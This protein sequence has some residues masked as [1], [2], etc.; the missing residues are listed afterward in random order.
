MPEPHLLELD[1]VPRPLDEER[2]RFL[3][4]RARG[5]G[6]SDIAA[7]LGISPWKSALEVYWEKTGEVEVP[8]KDNERMYWGTVTEDLIA[9]ECARRLEVEV[10]RVNDPICVDG[11]PWKRANID[12]RIVGTSIGPAVQPFLPDGH[13]WED[14]R[15]GR[16]RMGLECKQASGWLLDEWVNDNI[17]WNYQCQVQWCLYVTGW[18][19]WVFSG[20]F[21]GNDL[22]TWVIERDDEAIGRIVEVVERFWHDHVEKGCPPPPGP[23]EPDEAL[24]KRLWPE[25]DPDRQAD[26]TTK[27]AEWREKYLEANEA[28]KGWEEQKR[29]AANQIRHHMQTAEVILCDDGSKITWKAGKEKIEFD[30]KSFL[31]RF[32]EAAK[33][34]L[35]TE[36]KEVTSLDEE[37][38]RERYPKVASAFTERKVTRTLRVGKPKKTKGK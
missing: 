16:R 31:S 17:P 14:Y 2:R 19:L 37:T 22:R 4:E 9:R 1:Y 3:E 6:S 21:G 13:R 7:I 38:L 23:S 36:T 5:V 30:A 18:D 10:H 25:H 34:L 29:E 8:N 24:T 35:I 27:V 11:E 26:Y 33:K 12:R 28:I 15:D 32:P 20:L